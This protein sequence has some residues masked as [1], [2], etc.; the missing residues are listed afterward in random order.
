MAIL[1]YDV[2]FQKIWA[3][4]CVL[5]NELPSYILSIAC[6]SGLA[7][8]SKNMP[9]L[10]WVDQDRVGPLSSMVQFV[11]MLVQITLSYSMHEFSIGP[12]LMKYLWPKYLLTDT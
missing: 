8:G 2:H 10:L 5:K 9:V 12:C 4:T 11:F 7:L 3:K 1:S 6:I